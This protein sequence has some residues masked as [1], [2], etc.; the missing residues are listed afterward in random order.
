M[1]LS[2][3]VMVELAATDVQIIDG[4]FVGFDE[5]GLPQL[6]FLM[7]DSG[8]WEIWSVRPTDYAGIREAFARVETVPHVQ[9][10]ALN[11]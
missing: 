1:Q 2:W 4:D 11:H 10:E 6:Q 7:V 5:A 9:P 3:S 8:H